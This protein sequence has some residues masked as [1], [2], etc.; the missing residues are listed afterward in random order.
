MAIKNATFKVMPSEFVTILGPNGSGKT[1]FLRLALGLIK[2]DIGE[3][4]LMGKPAGSLE[5]RHL[6]GYIP[7]R[8]NSFNNRFPSTVREI[9]SHGLY[10]GFDPFRSF[11]RGSK[12]KVDVALEMSGISNLENRKFAD[13]S[14]GQQ[15]RTLISRALVRKPR[16]LLMDEPVAGIDV[17]GRQQFHGLLKSLNKESNVTII[18]VSHDIGAVM[19]EATTC[20]C[21]NKEIVFHG[22]VHKLTTKELQDLYG[23]PVDIMFHDDEHTHR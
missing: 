15:Q 23:F 2:P 17:G 8:V 6:V 5:N 1:T 4:L 11:R 22:P 14:V 20:A 9:V 19:R 7:Q 18:M 16:V 10:T 3:V 12:E 21:I 13:L